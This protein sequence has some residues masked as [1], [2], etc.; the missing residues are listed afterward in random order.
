MEKVDRIGSLRF[1]LYT[2]THTPLRHAAVQHKADIAT[3]NG[4]FD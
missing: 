4:Y 3:K 2:H 1:I